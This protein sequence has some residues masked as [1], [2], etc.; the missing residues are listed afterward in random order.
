MQWNGDFTF[1][2]SAGLNFGT[3]PVTLG[4]TRTV[5]VNSP[6]LGVNTNPLTIGGV[7]AGAAFGV[8]KTGLGTLVLSGANTFGSTTG[9]TLNLREGTWSFGNAAA[10]GSTNNTFTIS[11]LDGPVALDA[12]AA[13]T[14]SNYAAMNWNADFAFIGANTLSTGAPTAGITLSGTRTITALASTLTIAGV[15]NNTNTP[16]LIVN[17]PGTVAITGAD[18]YTGTTTVN[19]GSILNLGSA[20]AAG[21]LNG[22][23]GTAL[24]LNGGTFTYSRTGAV[25]QNMNG[26]TVNAGRGVINDTLATQTMALG[27]ITRNFGGTLD[28]QPTGASV[29]STTAGNTSGILGGWAT[30]NSGAGWAVGNGASAISALS[31]YTSDAWAAGNNT[32]VT[33]SSAPTSGSTT[34]SLR[35]NAAS[36]STITLSGTNTITSGGILL[37]PT[38]A[39]NNQIINGGTITAPQR[40]R[41]HHQPVGDDRHPCDQLGDRRRFRADQVGHLHRE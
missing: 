26:V 27:G 28:F 25:T 15:I 2:G 11:G 17:G 13:I 23:T 20:G 9:Q 41:S 8:N 4:A 29:L 35:F 5:T 7:V 39:A 3:T 12:S 1:K 6:G 38:V 21:S 30:F 18:L 32:T 10:L 37:T 36:A 34:Y 16:G 22:T 19:S 40:Q 24:V 33:T 31:S 14:L